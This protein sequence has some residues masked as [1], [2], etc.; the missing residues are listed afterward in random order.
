MKLELINGPNLDRLGARQVEI[1]G[2]QG[3]QELHDQLERRFPTV[4]WSFFQSNH[5]GELLDRLHSVDERVDGLILNPGGLS[6]TSVVLL[7]ALLALKAP[8]VEVH[9]SQVLAREEF[10]HTLLS[11]RGA[12]ALVCGMGLWGYEAAAH[13]LLRLREEACA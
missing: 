13:H 1:Y 12:C 2:N 8:V 7:D 6:H 5:E 11:A 9:I 3:L 10:R 4:Q